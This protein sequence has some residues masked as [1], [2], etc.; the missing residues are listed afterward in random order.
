MKQEVLATLLRDI[1]DDDYVIKSLSSSHNIA[2]QGHA[3]VTL[4]QPTQEDVSTLKSSWRSHKATLQL[5]GRFENTQPDT[6]RA[7]TICTDHGR[8][9]ARIDII[10]P[11]YTP[12][13]IIPAGQPVPFI[14]CRT[15]PTPLETARLFNLGTD[16][17][18][19]FLVFADRLY[20]HDASRQHQLLMAILGSAGMCFRK[21]KNLPV[22]MQLKQ[23]YD[24]RCTMQVF[25]T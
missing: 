8:T 9:S 23:L 7:L 21:V 3:D 11:Q 5:Q 25:P 12:G 16:Q 14:R 15:P 2:P 1:P 10:Q 22:H 19:P 18:L 4:F 13:Y 24:T 6:T 17:L 20:N